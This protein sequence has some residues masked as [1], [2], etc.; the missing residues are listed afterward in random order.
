[1]KFLKSILSVIT[2]AI[3]SI[4]N[5]ILPSNQQPNNFLYQD[6][7][8]NYSELS[9]VTNYIPSQPNMSNYTITQNASSTSSPNISNSTTSINP[10]YMSTNAIIFYI[11]VVLFMLK[12]LIDL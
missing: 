6:S 2:I 7:I 11:G 12:I 9:D 10:V 4:S 3:V 8:T 5:L 1:M